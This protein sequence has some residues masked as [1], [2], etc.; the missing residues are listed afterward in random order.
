MHCSARVE[1][2]PCSIAVFACAVVVAAACVPACAQGHESRS[3][4]ARG[5]AVLSTQPQ[6]TATV[7]LV[8]AKGKR[9]KCF[10]ARGRILYRLELPNEIY[11]IN[12]HG[13]SYKLY[14]DEKRCIGLTGVGY[15]GLFAP[16]V[17]FDDLVNDPEVKLDITYT[18]VATVSGMSCDKYAAYLGGSKTDPIILFVAKRLSNLVV[19]IEVPSAKPG[20]LS[21]R[22]YTLSKIKVG[23]P[24]RR[25]LEVPLDCGSF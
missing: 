19:R 9:S 7:T 18:G 3:G 23:P 8:D 13:N 17:Y 11:L 25:L 6:F 16:W 10:L 12:P 14:P 2:L 21:F 5:R 24:S 4:A 22:A 20:W 1:P 15:E